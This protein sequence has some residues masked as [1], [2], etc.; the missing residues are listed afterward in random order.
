MYL[1]VRASGKSTCFDDDD[2]WE[3]FKDLKTLDTEPPG[4]YSIM[5]SKHE[6][7]DADS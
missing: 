5:I 7:E 6:D 2:E 3:E 1:F 4:Q